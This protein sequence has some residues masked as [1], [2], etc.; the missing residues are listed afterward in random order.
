MDQARA[1]GK[2][3]VVALLSLAELLGMATWFSASAVVPT[4][5][6]EWSLDASGRSWL[7][8]SVQIGFVAGAFGSA[9]LNMADR[10]PSRWLF[11]G[12][13]AFAGLMTL[14]IPLVADGLLVALPLRV[15]TGVALAGVYPVGMKIMAT[16]TQHDRGL[17]IGLIVG[18]LTVGSALPHLLRSF[19]GLGNWQLV[20]YLAAGLAGLAAL[21]GALFVREGPHAVAA[22]K[23]NW[24]YIGDI[25]RTRSLVLA[26]LGYLGHMWELYAMWAWIP[27]FLLASFELSGI[28]ATWAGVT[29]FGAIAIGGLGSVVAGKLADRLGRTLI[30]SAAMAVSGASAL[31]VGLLFGASPVFLVP[32]VLIWG[33]AVVADS[34]QFSACISELGERAYMG[35]ALTL[36]T[37]LG[38]LL[39]L[40]SIRLVPVFEGRWGWEWAFTFLAIGPA[41]GIVAM[42]SLRGLPEARRLAGGNR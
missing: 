28:S 14:L 7:T 10:L 31:A 16:W 19:G 11:A 12:S 26:N 41:L 42:W 15:L 30:T 33:F 27:V 36:Q 4:L 21:I 20:L 17:G 9:I 32:L 3:K 39:T 23:F 24:T 22:P 38:F 2:W 5:T 40:A 1:G 18:A 13:A 25:A 37:S 35:T 29:A 8:M 34:A 6:D